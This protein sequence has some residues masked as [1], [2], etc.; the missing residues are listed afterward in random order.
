MPWLPLIDEA[1]L[2]RV[3]LDRAIRRVADATQGVEWR[4]HVELPPPNPRELVV[5]SS[6]VGAMNERGAVRN[7]E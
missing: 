7:T 6:T 4:T 3:K 2:S 5:V 1:R